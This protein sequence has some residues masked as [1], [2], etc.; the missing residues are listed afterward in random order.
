GGLLHAKC[1]LLIWRGWVRFILGSANLTSAGYR[2]QIESMTA[3][4]AHEGSE[5][6]RAVFGQALDALDELVGLT[7]NDGLAGGPRRRASLVLSAA[8]KELRAIDLPDRWPGR[9]RTSV[10][11]TS[12][13]QPVF[14]SLAD[15]WS[16]GPP[17]RARVISPYFDTV[18]EN[19]ERVLSTLGE[20]LAER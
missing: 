19:C 6:P 5:V 8:R 4:D 20:Q 16:G 14:Q 11:L 15:V 18:E 10:A 2:R 1:G 9:M 13:G 12:P 7:S 3:F 17:R